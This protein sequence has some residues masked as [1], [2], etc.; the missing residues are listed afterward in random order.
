M[1]KQMQKAGKPVHEVDIRSYKIRHESGEC[2]SALEPRIARGSGLSR[3][4]RG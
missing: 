3:A 1:I 4:A 2:Q